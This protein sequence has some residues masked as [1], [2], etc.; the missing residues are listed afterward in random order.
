MNEMMGKSQKIVAVIKKK[1]GLIGSIISIALVAA[2]VVAVQR[3]WNYGN[4]EKENKELQAS[5][6]EAATKLEQLTKTQ[7]QLAHSEEEVKLLKESTNALK[8]QVSS[9][10]IEKEN[11]NNKLEELLNIKETAPVITR[12]LLDEQIM[13]YKMHNSLES[14]VKNWIPK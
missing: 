10:N 2:A 9:L 12:D 6:S 4:L 5:L 8:E 1:R 13:Q 7:E 14:L 11:L 3:A